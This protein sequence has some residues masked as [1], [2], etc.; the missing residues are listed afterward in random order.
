[1]NTPSPV[2]ASTIGIGPPPWA[3][4]DTYPRSDTPSTVP[5]TENASSPRT[6]GSGPVVTA[7]TSSTGSSVSGADAS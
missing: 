1:M 2:A 5:L 6:A 4:A 3:A 7:A